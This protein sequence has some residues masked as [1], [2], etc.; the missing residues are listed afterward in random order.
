MPP[1][2]CYLKDMHVPRSVLAD[3]PVVVKPNQLRSAWPR[4]CSSLHE[5][6]TCGLGGFGACCHRM[7]WIDFW[8]SVDSFGRFKTFRSLCT[9]SI[10]WN[11]VVTCCDSIS[12]PLVRWSM[13][14]LG[15]FRPLN[16]IDTLDA[17]W[18]QSVGWLDDLKGQE[19]LW[20]RL[21][22]G[23][24]SPASPASPAALMKS[25][26]SVWT[27]P[28]SQWFSR[29]SEVWSNVSH[30]LVTECTYARPWELWR[31]LMKM[32]T[33]PN[34]YDLDSDWNVA[35]VKSAS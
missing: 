12:K 18:K 3:D 14:I 23:S 13:E 9:V 11:Q 16:F 6:M 22:D 1:V 31:A 2:F 8:T 24:G 30:P 29:M 20:Y 5:L 28:S 10:G 27:F 25:I 35:C 17:L 34:S 19:R 33:G 15:T 7:P 21:H 26:E 4:C 32:A